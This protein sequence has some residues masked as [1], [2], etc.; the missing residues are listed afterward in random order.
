[1]FEQSWFTNNNFVNESEDEFEIG[2]FTSN[3]YLNQWFEGF[4]GVDW[5]E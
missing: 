3:S 1:M 4:E 5:D 2:W